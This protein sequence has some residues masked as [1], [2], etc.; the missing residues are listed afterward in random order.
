MNQ[1][2]FISEYIFFFYVKDAETNWLFWTFNYILIKIPSQYRKN[3]EEER[4]QRGI[5]FEE[6]QWWF[7]FHSSMW[8]I[9]FLIFIECNCDQNG[10]LDGNC[11]DDTGKCYCNP[12]FDGDKCET[13][14][15]G[16]SGFPNCQENTSLEI[17]L[18][19]IVI[20]IVILVLI[21][22]FGY[23]RYFFQLSIWLFTL[24]L[25]NIH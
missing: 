21:F 22:V 11:D 17:V 14:A 8:K 18:I 19:P 20:L 10:Q 1:F 12:G 6:I 13:C 7:F 24:Y 23:K 3:S 9:L 4:I 15:K 2:H 16:F 5:Q 25:Y